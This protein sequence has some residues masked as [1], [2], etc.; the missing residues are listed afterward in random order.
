VGKWLFWQKGVV[1][2]VEYKDS[3]ITNVNDSSQ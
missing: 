2:E 3:K 1:K